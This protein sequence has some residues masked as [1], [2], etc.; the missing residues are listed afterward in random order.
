MGIVPVAA[1]RGRPMEIVR[2]G[3]LT[4]IVDTSAGS[5]E[6]V[7]RLGHPSEKGSAR[8]SSCGDNGTLLIQQSAG[9]GS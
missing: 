9:A 6:R 1:H 2:R 5:L 3:P 7:L 4:A 8:S